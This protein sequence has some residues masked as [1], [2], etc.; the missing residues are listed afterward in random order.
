MKK[1]LSIAGLISFGVAVLAVVI[2]STTVTLTF[3]GSA[4][5]LTMGGLS[6]NDFATNFVL[7]VRSSSDASVPTNQWP[8]VFT[9]PATSFTNQG[10]Y[11]SD[12]TL[13]LQTTANPSF[14]LLQFTNY[15]TSGTNGG[16]GPFS[17]PVAWVSGSPPGKIKKVQ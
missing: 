17:S 4:D 12:W 16:I 9:A 3:N 10:P 11:G 5:P 15:N 2:P 8:V 1:T 13:Q 6:P 7:V 14:Y